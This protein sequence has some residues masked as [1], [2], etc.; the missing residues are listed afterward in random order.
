[1]LVIHTEDVQ[2]SENPSSVEET[3]RDLKHYLREFHLEWRYNKTLRWSYNTKTGFLGVG[4]A[5]TLTHEEIETDQDGLYITERS[6]GTKS[7]EDK[8]WMR[9]GIREWI[10][11][12]ADVTNKV[13]FV[14]NQTTRGTKEQISSYPKLLHYFRG[15]KPSYDKARVEKLEQE[16]QAEASK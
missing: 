7:D 2:F 13:F 9:S 8:W 5:Y 10:R 12:E 6:S 16:E 3:L 11:G 1:M 15:F 4:C 14:N